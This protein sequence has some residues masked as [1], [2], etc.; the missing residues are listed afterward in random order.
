M[1]CLSLLSLFYEKKPVTVKVNMVSNNSEIVL[2]SDHKIYIEK[3]LAI[4][5]I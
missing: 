2:T 3:I 4:N 5:L 1:S